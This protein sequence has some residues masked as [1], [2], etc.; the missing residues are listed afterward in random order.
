MNNKYV[1]VI[2]MTPHNIKL[3]TGFEMNST[4]Y[5]MQCL[6]GEDLPVEGRF[7][8]K[9]DAIE[10]LQALIATAR[11]SLKM[12]IGPVILVLPAHNYFP[13]EEHESVIVESDYN[14]LTVNDYST[15]AKRA[16][17]TSIKPGNVFFY[18]APYGFTV[19]N[20]NSIMKNFPLDCHTNSLDIYVD[21]HSIDR[22]AFDFYNLILDSINIKPYLT[23]I[24]PYC[25]MQYYEKFGMPESYLLLQLDKENTYLSYSN[26]NR[27]YFSDIIDGCYADVLKEYSESMNVSLERGQELIETFG[28]AGNFGFEYRTDEGQSMTDLSRRL[29]LSFRPL[30]QK[31]LDKIEEHQI[32]E[33]V[34]LYISG[35]VSELFG[36]D[37]YYSKAFSRSSFVTKVKT[38]GAPKG[39]FD[40]CLGAIYIA[41]MPYQQSLD[42]VRKRLSDYQL[43]E[44]TFDR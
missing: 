16:L 6:E 37:A 30:S 7:F 1:T 24:S 41:S 39:C 34:P 23:L 2:E 38:L 20:N 40:A 14:T 32:A 15:A 13:K 21:N 44:V 27:L 17:K 10:S 18:S 35:S 43:K 22:E 28:F 36:I 31:I 5:V 4:T 9:K 29:A 25:A 42:K 12:D 26:G 3:L 33:D 19:D 8:D 11:N